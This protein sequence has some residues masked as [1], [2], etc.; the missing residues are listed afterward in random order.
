MLT[1]TKGLV[2]SNMRYRE[3]SLLV[4]IY[5]AECGITTYI[6]NGVRSVKAKHKMALFQPLTLLD[7]EVF[8][9]PGKGIHRISSAKCY[10]P[11]RKIPFDIA[12]SSIALFLSEVLS[13]VLKEEEANPVLFEFLEASFQFLDQAPGH[14][15]NFH[16]QFLWNLTEFLGF[17]PGLVSEFLEQLR[18]AGVPGIAGIDA[19]ALSALFHADYGQEVLMKRGQRQAVLAALIYYYQLHMESFGDLRSLQILQEVLS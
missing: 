10:Y 19:E 17:Y 15:E 12:Y 5:T 16:L 7:L 13:K 8:H 3:S 14:T 1:K 2:I 9:K 4:T 18:V 6:E 11:Y